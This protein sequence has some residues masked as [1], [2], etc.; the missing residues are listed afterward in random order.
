MLIGFTA[1]AGP[2]NLTTPV[3]T[4][5]GEASAEAPGLV[6]AAGKP[7]PGIALMSFNHMENV[8]A[9]SITST[10]FGFM[11]IRPPFL[12]AG[13]VGLL[14]CRPTNPKLS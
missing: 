2:S 10:C 12:Y 13:C 1:D 14:E 4:A 5:G 3:K 6:G 9:A 11:V 8:K 7:A